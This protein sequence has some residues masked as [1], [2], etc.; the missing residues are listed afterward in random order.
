M[1]STCTWKTKELHEWQGTT[2]LEFLTSVGYRVKQFTSIIIL[3]L[4]IIEKSRIM[5]NVFCRNTLT[6]FITTELW[7]D[8]KYICSWCFLLSIVCCYLTVSHPV[9]VEIL[10]PVDVCVCVCVCRLAGGATSSGTMTLIR[11]KWDLA[12][13]PLHSL[14]ML[15]RTMPGLSIARTRPTVP[16]DWLI[17]NI[18]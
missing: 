15:T 12:W 16:S 1:K 7:F 17:L 9:T 5:P 6:S 3:I 8:Q 18:L 10:I 2:V 4:L 11:W 13:R 14:S